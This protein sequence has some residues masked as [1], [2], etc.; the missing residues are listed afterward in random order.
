MKIGLTGGI[1]SGKSTVSQI[2]REL[3]ASI[4]DADEIARMLAAPN[5]PL[6]QAIL[7][8]FGTAVLCED[9]SL[10]RQTLGDMVFADPDCK[11]KLDAL[12]HPLIQE[13][14][15]R[16]L[17]AAENNAP[18]IVLDVPLLFEAGWEKLADECW[19]VYVDLETQ[20]KRLMA[21]NGYST[22]QAQERIASQMPLEEK[23]R[24]ASFIIDN[25]RD[26]AYTRKQVLKRWQEI[27]EE[28]R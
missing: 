15:M 7:A 9:G 8:Q 19:V 16:Q 5:Q 12:A 18:V 6:Y 2:L 17:M 24:R 23:C 1:A 21:R 26:L 13:E 4:I 27:K 22:I 10:N 3:G 25:T 20:R 28:G 14:L 11:K